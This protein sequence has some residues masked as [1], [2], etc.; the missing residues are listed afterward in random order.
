MTGEGGISSVADTAFWVATLRGQESTRRD[1]VFHDPLA[2]LLAGPRGLKIAASMPRAAVVAWSMVVR[3]SA[4]DQLID[5]A[6]ATGTDCV[7]NLGAGLDT[8]PYR[9]DLPS[10][11]RWIEIDFPH[12]VEFKNSALLEHKPACWVER[13]GLDLLDRRS[14]MEVLEKFGSQTENALLIAEG[15]IPYFSNDDI[16]TLAGDLYVIPSFRTWILDFD[17]AGK[18]RMPREWEK[19]MRAAPFLFEVADWFG[20]FRQF[21]WHPCKVITSAEQSEKI[22]RPYP[23]AFPLG[24]LMYTLP[25]AVRRKILSLSGAVLLQK[26]QPR[27]EQ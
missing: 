10:H 16:A 7:V 20:F 13:V 21:G 4:I 8:R 22:N 24:L 14:R 11:V 9:M 18:R 12:I 5:E 25:P 27:A 3:T 23:L 26:G 6:L 17:D 19:R 15:V 2:T 1:A